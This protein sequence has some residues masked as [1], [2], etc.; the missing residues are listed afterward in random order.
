MAT[1]STK[2]DRPQRAY[3]TM[4]ESGANAGH[5]VQFPSSFNTADQKG[6]EILSYTFEFGA[7]IDYTD[8][9][10]ANEDGFTFG[11]GHLYFSGVAP[12][13]RVT[14]GVIDVQFKT[15]RWGTEVGFAL[16]DK[17]FTIHFSVPVIAHPASLYA[18]LR[19][20]NLAAALGGYI[21]IDYRLIDLPDEDYKDILQSI[22]IQN[23]I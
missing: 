18:Y 23:Q 9:F 12:S 15:F 10:P 6:I 5:V 14:P 17:Q 7:T 16:L 1:R 20:I 21:S 22:L 13:F 8:L 11:I 2:L 19:G 3:V 4:L